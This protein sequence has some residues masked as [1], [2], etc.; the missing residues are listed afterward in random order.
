MGT[1]GVGDVGDRSGVSG[2]QAERA[3]LAHGARGR[4]DAPVTLP[5]SWLGGEEEGGGHWCQEG[6]RVMGGLGA[7]ERHFGFLGRTSL[8]VP[9]A[10]G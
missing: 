3:V 10:E 1:G 2:P 7:G 9:F 4:S 8:P 6:G 5:L